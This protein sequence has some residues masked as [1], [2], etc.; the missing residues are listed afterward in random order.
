MKYFEAFEILFSVLYAVVYGGLGGLASVA[1]RVVLE[2]I[3]RLILIPREAYRAASGFSLSGLRAVTVKM[4]K[5]ETPPLV[6]LFA[7]LIFFLLFGVG[8][9]LLSYFALDGELRLYMLLLVVV[10]YAVCS[11]TV[12][13]IFERAFRE[14]YRRAYFLLLLFLSFALVPIKY[15]VSSIY[16]MALLPILRYIRGL[17]RRLHHRLLVNIKLKMTAREIEKC[18]KLLKKE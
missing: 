13:K 16:I 3:N 4:F 14:L 17:W 11:H 12:G 6:T 1:T 9:L 8:F 5:K 18:A 2:D 7:E 15:L 10:S